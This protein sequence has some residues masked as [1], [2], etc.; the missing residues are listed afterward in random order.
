MNEEEQ[1]R[2]EYEELT[3]GYEFA[4]ASFQ[5][6]SGRL[7]T[8]LNAVGDKNRIYEEN[9]AVPPMTIAALAMAAMSSG[10]VLPPG[11]IHVSQNLE[12]V[13]EVRIG[14][15]L[16]SQAKVSR[17]VERGKFHMLNVSIN[18]LNQHK[19][20]VLTGETAFI[21]PLVAETK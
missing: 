18:V 16:T 1:P 19:N 9:K 3:T 12:F 11:A 10:L 7:R 6:D 21:L 15:E 5:L 8:Y 2:I 20:I 13:K 4:P 14:E 17:K